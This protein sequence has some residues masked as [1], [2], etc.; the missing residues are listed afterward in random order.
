MRLLIDLDS[1]IYR[2]LFA[3]K[4]SNYYKQVRVCENLIEKAAD[5]VESSDITLFLSGKGNFRYAIY[6]DYKANRKGVERP[7]YLHDARQYFIKYWN[8][9]CEDD[10]EADDMIAMNHDEDSVIV[11]SDKDFNTVGGNILNPFT[12]V[13]YYVKNPAFHFY[14][15][16]LVGDMVDNIPGVLNPAKAHHKIPPN[17]TEKT[18]SEELLDKTKEEMRVLV[19]AMYENEYREEWFKFYD[20]NAQL[21]F[22]KRSVESSYK[23]FY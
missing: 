5:R 14:K 18:A 11:S 12:N 10:M 16:L 6:P 19:Q 4:Y 15:Q 9:V 13:L 17:F 7:F 22:L 23:D 2:G 1:I 3:L 8:A 20:R 21:L